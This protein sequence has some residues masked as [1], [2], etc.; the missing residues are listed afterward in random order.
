M[1]KKLCSDYLPVA[2]K[3]ASFILK[4]IPAASEPGILKDIQVLCNL[5]GT[6][7]SV[8]RVE[9]CKSSQNQMAQC[10]FNVF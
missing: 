6:T 2:S 7:L 3:V 4:N 8:G 5:T 9:N 1:A 10:F